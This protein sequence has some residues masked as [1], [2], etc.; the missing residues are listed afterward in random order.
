MLGHR[1]E[2]VYLDVLSEC[3]GVR[4]VTLS[5]LLSRCFRIQA[6]RIESHNRRFKLIFGTFCSVP[7]QLLL[8]NVMKPLT[9]V[10]QR[11]R[12]A[13]LKSDVCDISLTN[14][15]HTPNM[16]DC[17]CH[18]PSADQC[19]CERCCHKHGWLNVSWFFCRSML[20]WVLLTQC[21]ILYLHG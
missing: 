1:L 17:M 7:R 15:R 2:H 9:N 11:A 19:W 18:D 5:K 16:D 21:C 14:W 12:T 3:I 10:I 13:R 20:V 6:I 4:I 8:C